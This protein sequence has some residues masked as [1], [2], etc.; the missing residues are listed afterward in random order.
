MTIT[1]VSLGKT[2]AQRAVDTAAKKFNDAV[3]KNKNYIQRKS[4]PK[5]ASGSGGVDLNLTKIGIG[6]GAT[7]VVVGGILLWRSANRM[8]DAVGSFFGMDES[9]TSKKIK[10][11][12][13]ETVENAKTAK[14]ARR[15]NLLPTEIDARVRTLYS[16]MR[17]NWTSNDEEIQ[18]IFNV[19]TDPKLNGKDLQEIYREFGT[20][21]YDVISNQDTAGW[22]VSLGIG[23]EL[24]LFGWF[25][26]EITDPDL[27]RGLSNIWE[28]K[29]GMSFATALAGV[30]RIDMR[31]QAMAN[32][33]YGLGLPTTIRGLR[34]NNPGNLRSYGIGWQGKTGVDTQGG[35][36]QDR[37]F[38][39]FDDVV[40]GI[41]ALMINLHTQINRGHDTIRKLI[42]V[43]AP[44]HEN[45][46]E[47]YV[48]YVVQRTGIPA[49]QKINTHHRVLYHLTWAIMEHENGKGPARSLIP[50]RAVQK[51]LELVR[52]QKTLS[53]NLPDG[54]RLDPATGL[55]KI[56]TAGYGTW[57]AVGGSAIV[58]GSIL[59]NYLSETPSKSKA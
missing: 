42:N 41:R 8:G 59:Y 26:H 22:V 24:D 50:D 33:L 12:I 49:G 35:L 56:Q 20:R 48:N 55:P 13:E 23:E 16:A 25:Q 53:L 21:A 28:A 18:A 9:D 1:A 51:A 38:V 10:G 2:T 34:N 52:D 54:L 11:R 7:A 46:V 31:G 6:V 27:L 57:L 4:A 37:G 45:N 43:W 30:G 32:R 36:S 40:Y 15:P 14:N 5:A 58:G 17:S 39:I 19:V 44:S 3:K 29:A 47:A